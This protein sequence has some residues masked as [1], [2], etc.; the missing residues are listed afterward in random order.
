MEGKH[1]ISVSSHDVKG[2]QL[3]RQGR[4]QLYCDGQ[5]GEGSSGHQSHLNTKDHQ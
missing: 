1:T 5:I 3:L 4:L 2:F